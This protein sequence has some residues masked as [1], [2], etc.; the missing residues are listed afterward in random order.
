MARHYSSNEFF[1]QMPNALLARYFQ[2]R[3][4]FND[5]D[6]SAMKE[7]KPEEL[8][9]AWL[10]LPEGQRNAM[11]AELRE[12]FDMSCDKGFLAIIGEAPHQFRDTPRC[13][14]VET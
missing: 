7:G 5:L 3:G 6:F 8:F 4:L 1:R 14:Y 2:A 12:I 9:V 11:D 13:T 10:I